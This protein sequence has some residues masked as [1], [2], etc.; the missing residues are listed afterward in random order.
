MSWPEPYTGA[1]LFGSS[2]WCVGLD[3]VHLNTFNNDITGNLLLS[4][5]MVY[6]VKEDAKEALVARQLI[7]TQGM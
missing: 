7:F 1:L 2:Y 3:G 4:N 5:G 6:L